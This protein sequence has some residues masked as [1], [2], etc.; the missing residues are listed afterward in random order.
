MT[1]KLAQETTKTR[2]PTGWGYLENDISPLEQ[3]R[4][5]GSI[6]EMF[7][8]N[9][10]E[11]RPRPRAVD[12]TLSESRIKPPSALGDIVTIA[13]D[14][15]VLRCLGRSFYDLARLRE[16]PVIPAPDAV[17]CPANIEELTRVIEWA[18]KHNYALIPFGGGSSVVGGINVGGMEEHRAVITVDL[19]KMNKV[20]EVSERERVVHAEAG[21]LGPAL[22]A[23]LKPAGLV[24]RH[25][26]QS[27]HHSSLGGW[28]ATRGAGHNSILHAKIEDRVQAIEGILADGEIFATRPL[29]ATSVAIDPRSYWLGS[30]GILGFITSVRL[31]VYPVPR[32]RAFRGIAFDTFEQAL[33]ATRIVAQSDLFPVQLRVLD[34]D[35]YQN[36]LMLAGRAGKRQALMILADESTLPIVEDKLKLLSEMALSAGGRIDEDA[37]QV[38]RDWIRFFF[39]QPYMRDHFLD[40]GMVADTFE[41]SIPYGKIPDFYHQV[42]DAA[43]K[44]V[45]AVCGAGRIGCRVTHAY[46]DGVCLYY[47]FYGP[48]R[49]GSLASQWSDIRERVNDA[50][51][52][53][54]G[55][56]SHHHAMGRDHKKW[57]AREFPAIHRRAIRKLKNEL[58]PKKQMNPGLWFNED[59]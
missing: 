21:I 32:H 22:D 27:Y 45:T 55:T 29:P 26:P 42:R 40:W 33:E 28:V 1:K 12:V 30:E 8:A 39:K 47:S 53:A 19:Q 46:P 36:T 48:G 34:P 3:E 10:L 24:A 25:M 35:E 56:I 15:R 49:H 5:K 14:E 41:T 11:S 6:K 37:S 13:Q 58:D 57:A 9:G 18:G 43:I 38:L 59:E 31:R 50:L 17:A 2:N 51:I 7:S 16:E 23:A 44:A 4:L 20:L 54:G 52:A